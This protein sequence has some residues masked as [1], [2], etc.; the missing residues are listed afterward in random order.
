MASGTNSGT[1]S[2][3]DPHSLSPV[4]GG[5]L[6]A[7]IALMRPLAAAQGAPRAPKIAK[8]SQNVKGAA[9]GANHSKSAEANQ[10]QLGAVKHWREVEITAENAKCTEIELNRASVKI[11]ATLKKGMSRKTQDLFRNAF[12]TAIEHARA[13]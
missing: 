11:Q 7:Q 3:S 1:P 8:N 6:A 2:P 4:S 13:A 12:I 5:P 10:S 9:P